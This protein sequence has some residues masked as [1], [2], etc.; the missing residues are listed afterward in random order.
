MVLGHWQLRYYY[1]RADMDNTVTCRKCL[2]RQESDGPGTGHE[3]T[4]LPRAML[5][6]PPFHHVLHQYELWSYLPCLR[7]SIHPRTT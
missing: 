2:S 1:Q 4:Y 6:V 3:M 5:N 7:P